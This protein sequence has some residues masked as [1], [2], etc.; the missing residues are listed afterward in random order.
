MAGRA[1]LQLRAITSERPGEVRIW[2]PVVEVSDRAGVLCLTVTNADDDTAA[3]CED[4][5]LLANAGHPL[6]LLVR[7]GRVISQLEAHRPCHG[8]SGHYSPHRLGP[9][10]RVATCR[11]RGAPRYLF[12]G[13]RM[14]SQRTLRS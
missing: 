5:G 1:F 7:Q 6:P 14:D 12:D 10:A 11:Y 3:A 13:F 4:L 2:V 9:S 8:G